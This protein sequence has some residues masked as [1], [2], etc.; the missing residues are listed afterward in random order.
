MEGRGPGQNSSIGQFF[1]VK[2]AHPWRARTA[3]LRSTSIAIA[4]ASIARTTG[5]RRARRRLAGQ[6]LFAP[7][8]HSFG[9]ESGL[10]ECP[11]RLGPRRA[12]GFRPGINPANDVIGQ[13]DSPHRIKSS[14]R[15]SKLLFAYYMLCHATVL[16]NT[17]REGKFSGLH[18]CITCAI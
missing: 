14:R 16:Q 7:A 3:S 5:H 6:S 13:A 2:I 4:P 10:A 9:L 15:A 17:W 11:D 1:V 12:I 8:A 18:F